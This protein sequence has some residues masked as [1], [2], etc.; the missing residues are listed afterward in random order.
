MM[1]TESNTKPLPEE[2]R[3]R[4]MPRVH[5]HAKLSPPWVTEI[6]VAWSHDVN[7]LECASN[8]DYLYQLIEVGKG[9]YA[10]TDKELELGIIHEI[11]HAYTT[12]LATLARDLMEDMDL[13]EAHK[14]TAE[15][16]ITQCLEMSTEALAQKFMAL[17]GQSDV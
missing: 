1:I 4:I 6:I 3:E 13:G 15:R 5:R 11:V 2:I 8:K 10:A 16:S 12:P 14:K 17:E 7:L 9:C